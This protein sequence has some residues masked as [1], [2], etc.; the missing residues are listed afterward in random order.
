MPEPSPPPTPLPHEQLAEEPDLK[1][2]YRAARESMGRSAAE[3]L[4]SLIELSR[5]ICVERDDPIPGQPPTLRRPGSGA[6]TV[7][8]SVP[9]IKPSTLH[10]AVELARSFTDAQLE[11]FLTRRTY[12][13]DMVTPAHLRAIAGAPAACRQMLI[14]R[15]Y[16][17]AASVQFLSKEARR[18]H[19]IPDKDVAPSFRNM[20][21]AIQ[22]V[23]MMA[24]TMRK[25][26]ACEL[27]EQLM[28]KLRAYA[29]G[30]VVPRPED[31]EM[32]SRLSLELT[33]LVNV[34][35]EVSQLAV[36]AA[37]SCPK[38]PSDSVGC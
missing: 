37:A 9:G 3:T 6:V 14:D 30:Q 21:H 18:R 7:L 34:A 12:K 13:G 26:L 38:P 5:I 23:T 20:R 27:E 10:E 1:A 2:R 25:R 33:E 4:R 29:A 24:T 11:S 31:R 22:G 8:T 36:K 16:E 19:G 32:I 28:S 35:N 15:Y 17:R